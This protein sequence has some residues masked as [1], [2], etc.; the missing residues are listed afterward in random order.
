MENMEAAPNTTQAGS[1]SAWLEAMRDPRVDGWP[2]MGSVWPTLALSSSY[3]LL[4][5]HIGPRLMASRW[6]NKRHQSLS[7]LTIMW[8]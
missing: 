4:V 1:Y 5:S 7:T 8:V 3:Y 6:G 2:L